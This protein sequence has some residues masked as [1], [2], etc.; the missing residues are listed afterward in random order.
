MTW[1]Q[2]INWPMEGPLEGP[3]ELFPFLT[4]PFM[5]EINGGDPNVKH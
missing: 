4:W 3:L 2:W 5:A 1:F